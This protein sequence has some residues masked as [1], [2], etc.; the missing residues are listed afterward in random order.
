MDEMI[1]RTRHRRNGI[2]QVH[3]NKELKQVTEETA[4]FCYLLLPHKKLNDSLPCVKTFTSQKRPHS[5]YVTAS[6]IQH[7]T[8]K[9]LFLHTG[10]LSHSQRTNCKDNRIW[11]K[12]L[13]PP[14]VL[15]ILFSSYGVPK[16]L[17]VSETGP[18]FETS[19]WFRNSVVYYGHNLGNE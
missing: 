3:S 16:P 19:S 8:P 11:N 7:T 14:S 10:H 4:T 17:D 12:K 15:N 18:V 6:I 1:K 2:Q 13:F 9:T 5:H